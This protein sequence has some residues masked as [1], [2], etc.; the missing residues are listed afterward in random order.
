MM[1]SPTNRRLP[2]IGLVVFAVVLGLLGL[3]YFIAKS[4][5]PLDLKKDSKLLSIVTSLFTSKNT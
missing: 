3:F 1:E 4:K 5:A 2:K